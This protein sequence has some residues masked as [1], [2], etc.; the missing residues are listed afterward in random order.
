[1][2]FPGVMEFLQRYQKEAA[3]KG[4]DPL[5]YYL[6][7]WA[8]AD[9]QVLGKA[10][11]ETRNLDQDQIAEYIR[12]HTFKTVIG[13]VTFGEKGEWKKARLM[14]VQFQNIAGAGVDDFR[15]GKGEVVVWPEEYRAGDPILPF[16]SVKH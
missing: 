9:L 13:D 16:S 7:P 6:A 15:D 10:V 8:Y 12:T 3:R 14:T 5:G 1:L 11:A 2:R 4:V